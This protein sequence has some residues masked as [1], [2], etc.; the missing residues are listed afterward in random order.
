[1]ACEFV[2]FR[3][4]AIDFSHQEWEYLDLV[5]KT[6]Y[7]E[8]MVKNYGIGSFFCYSSILDAL[9]GPDFEEISLEVEQSCSWIPQQRGD[10]KTR[11]NT[12]IPRSSWNPRSLLL[13]R[14]GF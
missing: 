8:V 4:M 14:G 12:A 13:P 11:G 7:Q 2:T 3:D 10:L 5:Q 9:E 6:L 1:M